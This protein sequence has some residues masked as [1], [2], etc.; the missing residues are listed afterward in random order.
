MVDT[1]WGDVIR[2]VDGDTFDVR[3][4]HY[5]QQ[6]RNRYNNTERIRLASANAPELTSL[7]GFSAKQQL[8]LRI[9]GKF[10][11]LTVHTRDIYGRLVCDMS[12]AT[13]T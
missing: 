1:L 8:E 11:H 6:N 7:L 10:V 12:L 3:V 2:V 13:R 9:S 4:T 5:N